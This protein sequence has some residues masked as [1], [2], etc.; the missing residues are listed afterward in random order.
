MGGFNQFDAAKAQY[1]A[2]NPECA[3]GWGMESVGYGWGALEFDSLTGDWGFNVASGGLSPFEYVVERTL[4]DGEGKATARFNDIVDAMQWANTDPVN[5]GKFKIS[6]PHVRDA[7][8][9]LAFFFK[10]VIDV[11]SGDRTR[12]VKGSSANSRHLVWNGGRAADFHVRGLSDEDAFRTLRRST[13]VIDYGFTLIRHGDKTNTGGP[14]L[15]LQWDRAPNRPSI[16]KVEGLSQATFGVY[17][18]V[19]R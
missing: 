2:E 13:G 16:F 12:I 14:H 4:S 5:Y 11:T 10:R 17:S 15:H 19:P 18:V 7:L 6:D 8:V 9:L 1:C 3:Q